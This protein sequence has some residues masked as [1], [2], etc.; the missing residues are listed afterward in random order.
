MEESEREGEV[1]ACV[2]GAEGRS[3]EEPKSRVRGLLACHSR[4]AG[5]VLPQTTLFACFFSTS[6][7]SLA[8]RSNQCSRP[9]QLMTRGRE[10]DM[11][12]E[13]A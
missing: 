8:R 4:L 13:G 12:Q 6:F 7:Y 1:A 11:R 2:I 10:L 5:F 9:A 3:T